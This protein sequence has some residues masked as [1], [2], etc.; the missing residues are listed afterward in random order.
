[1]KHTLTLVVG[2]SLFSGAIFAAHAAPPPT[3]I[4]KGEWTYHSV[5]TI[6]DGIM[7]GH[8][9]SKSWKTCVKSES[10]A[11][12]SLVPHSMTGNTT[13]SKPTLSYSEKGYHTVMTCVTKA[14]G[15]TS[16]VREDFLLKAGKNG[17]T[18]KAHGKVLEQLMVH[19]MPSRKM[20]M[21]IDIDGK[22][23]GMCPGKS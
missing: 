10:D 13:C 16:K 6:K 21:T 8:T 11:A 19:S 7:A 20:H 23:T 1:M 14:R 5:V 3:H 12:R 4:E 15:M 18:F 2:L 22:R 17:T 9:V